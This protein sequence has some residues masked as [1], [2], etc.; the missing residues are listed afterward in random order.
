MG[1]ITPNGKY[2]TKRLFLNNEIQC[3]FLSKT[4]DAGKTT[5]RGGGQVS[6]RWE[7][8]IITP[9]TNLCAQ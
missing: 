8:K 7:K 4:I 6:L 3:C 5:K 1:V 2:L 9:K